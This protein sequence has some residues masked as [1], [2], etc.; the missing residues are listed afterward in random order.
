MALNSQQIVQTLLTVR[1]RLT[2]AVWLI[3][4]D[5]QTAEDIFQEVSVKALAADLHFD[6]KPE[7]VSW[8]HIAARHQALNW[9][10]ARR[11]QGVLLDERVLELLESEWAGE[12]A[13]PEG[14]RI[15]ALRQCLEQLPAASR[16]MIQLRYFDERPCRDVAGALGVKLDAVYQRLARVH[17]ALGQCIEQRLDTSGPMS[18]EAS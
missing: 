8:A 18:S 6:R 5:A 15:E 1:N 14:E 2:A 16:R 10:R 9:V 4:H 17:R 3:V 12:T 7:L 11:N 13:R